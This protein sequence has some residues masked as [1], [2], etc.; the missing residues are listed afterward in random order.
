MYRQ[1][2]RRLT[3]QTGSL[4]VPDGRAV[5]PTINALLSLPFPFKLATQDWHPKT[6]TSFS[7]NHPGTYPFTSTHTITHPSDPSRTYTT[8]LWPVHCVQD[9]PGAELL[10]ELKKEVL[11]GMFKKGTIEGVETYSAFYDPFKVE[12][13]GLV[14]RLRA[15]GITSVFVVG[16][17][18]DYCVR[19]TALDAQ[20]EG[21]ETFVVEEG[22]RCVDPAAWAGVRAEMEG[23]GVRVVSIVGEEVARVRALGP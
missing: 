15:E 3:A 18:G 22:T 21:F 12:D 10:P 6:H 8:T 4:A 23:A 11:D 17:A 5:L 1:E 16:L 19:C 14:E 2:S 13:T 9:T 7:A 20:M